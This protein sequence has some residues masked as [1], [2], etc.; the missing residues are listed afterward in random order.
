MAASKPMRAL[1]VLAAVG[2]VDAFVPGAAARVAGPEARMG[3]A[4]PRLQETPAA[5]SP[6][7]D[8]WQSWAASVLGAAAA[9][10]LAV[11]VVGAPA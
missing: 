5:E 11:G 10:G 8:G 7:T 1:V 9:L 4:A 6:A 3:V 2:A